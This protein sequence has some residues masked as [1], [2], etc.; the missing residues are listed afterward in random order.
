M[1]QKKKG[2][3]KERNEKIKKWREG[4]HQPEQNQKANPELEVKSQTNNNHSWERKK[5]VKR[6]IRQGMTTTSPLT[7]N[8]KPHTQP[9]LI[10]RG[11]NRARLPSPT[12]SRHTR[13]CCLQGFLTRCN[14]FR[15]MFRSRGRMVREVI[16]YLSIGFVLSPLSVSGKRVCI[17]RRWMPRKK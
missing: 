13:R 5:K 1:K 12:P 15:R 16:R 6:K 3:W 8:I 4:M 14:C 11:G 2:M 17:N 7:S 9:H 10:R